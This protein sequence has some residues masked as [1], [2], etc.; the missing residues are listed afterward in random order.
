MERV[1]I[2]GVGQTK[3]E[4]CKEDQGFADLVYEATTKALED[5]GM[6]I[7]DIG[8]VITVS[9][10]FWDGRTI[11][12]M[13][14][15]DACGAYNKNV[16]TVEGDGTFGALYGMM[17]VLSGYYDTTLVV[18]HCRASGA[19]PNQI[20]NAMFDPIYTRPL[21]L[22]AVS[23]SALQ[24][25]QYMERFGVSEEQCALISVKNHGNAKLNGY[26]IS[27]MELTVEDVMKSTM[28]ADPIKELDCA[29]LGDGACAV[30]IA[31]EQKA[32]RLPGKAVWI[33]GVAH[34]ADAYFLGDRDL[35]ETPAL[36][37][38]ARKAYEM[39]GIEDP[40]KEID[41]VELFDGFS[42]QELMWLEG[43]S[44]CRKGEAARLTERGVTALGGPLP[45][46]PSGGVLSGHVPQVAGL[47]R[48]AEAVLQVR[49][50]ADGHQVDG[51][52][53]A[54]AHGCH[55]PCGQGHC[56]WILGS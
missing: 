27:P 15:M 21:G 14:V 18:A 32:K 36:S 24:A 16:S 35:A 4:R 7:G 55:G 9:N 42:Y 22:D 1:A 46:N 53:T 54:L 41:V 20:T 52:R 30:I 44:L 34:C 23:S 43:L 28:L 31:G 47:A 38:A 51:V 37:K 25:R 49:G 5:A 13:A 11:S 56:V 29:T 33:K 45:V 48:I 6:S 40:A 10:D 2:I 17:R 39:A 50:E 8:N 26:A 19:P 12:S 3:Y